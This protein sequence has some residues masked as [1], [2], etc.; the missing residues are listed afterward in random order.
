M[1]RKSRGKT[2]ATAYAYCDNDDVDNDGLDDGFEIN[3]GV[4]PLD[5]DCDNDGLLDGLEVNNYQTDPEDSDTDGD[6]YD[7]LYEIINGYDPLDP[8]DYP[9]S[10]GWG[11]G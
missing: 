5:N 8:D 10:G 6:S 3:L 1:K 11:W 2:N 4:D 9:G 7:D